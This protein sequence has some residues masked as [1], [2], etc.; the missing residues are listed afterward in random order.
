MKMTKIFRILPL[1]F[2][3]AFQVQAQE[4]NIIAQVP[5]EAVA[6]V[7]FQVNIH[8]YKGSLTGFARFQQNFPKAVSIKSLETSGAD[9][10]FVNGKVNA[11]WLNLPVT[12]DLF[13]QYEVITSPQVKG[14]LVF[15]GAF[16]YLVNDDRSE[17]TMTPV[18]VRILP[19]PKADISRVVN[20][21]DYNGPLPEETKSEIRYS[22]AAFR[23][24]PYLL[25]NEGWQV[26]VLIS[27]GGLQKLARVE[28]HVP[29]GYVA[30]KIEARN[31]IFSFKGG[32]A[33]FLWMILPADPY[34][35]VSYKLIPGNGDLRIQIGRAHV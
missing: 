15:Q 4:I 20:I 23:E 13:I 27:R 31:A 22:V 33:K 30:E 35:I 2:F 28:E 19:S 32:V 21:Q 25:G 26:N 24:A 3:M 17:K 1:F 11:I 7:P 5:D 14:D 12:G 8:I 9:F 10:S 34:F 18:S 6:G 16:S 29:S